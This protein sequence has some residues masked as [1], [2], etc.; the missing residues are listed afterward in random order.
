VIAATAKE[1]NR[2]CR[3]IRTLNIFNYYPRKEWRWGV[4][5][6]LIRQP[7]QGSADDAV[8]QIEIIIIYDPDSGLGMVSERPLY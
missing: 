8:R 4:Q 6:K 2:R 7:P 5:G 3:T 1:I